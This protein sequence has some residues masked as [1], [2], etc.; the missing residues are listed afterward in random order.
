M[1]DQTWWE[2]FLGKPGREIT[3]TKEY[4]DKPKEEKKVKVTSHKIDDI[5]EFSIRE[6]NGN[7][8]VVVQTNTHSDQYG[9]LEAATWLFSPGSVQSIIDKLTAYKDMAIELENKIHPPQPPKKEKEK[10]KPDFKVLNF[11]KKE[12]KEPEGVS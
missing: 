7:V 11:E 3:P 12:D 6:V 5:F 1:K 2:W 8:R 9:Y 10:E 4:P